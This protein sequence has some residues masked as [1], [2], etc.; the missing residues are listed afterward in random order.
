MRFCTNSIF[1]WETD[2]ILRCDSD[3]A[4]ASYHQGL[5]YLKINFAETLQCMSQQVKFVYYV[6]QLE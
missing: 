1:L 6:K 2:V 3:G 5:C 4:I